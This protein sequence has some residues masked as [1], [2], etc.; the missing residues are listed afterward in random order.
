[1]KSSYKI[2]AILIVILFSLVSCNNRNTFIDKDVVEGNTHEETEEVFFNDIYKNKDVSVLSMK[3]IIIK[4]EIY[5][6]LFR[7]FNITYDE[8][9]EVYENIFLAN[10]NLDHRVMVG[11]SNNYPETF[12]SS[13]FEKLKAYN[14]V[15]LS[16]DEMD[17]LIVETGYD[18]ESEKKFVEDYGEEGFTV[19]ISDSI[20]GYA[21]ESYIFVL[22]SVMQKP[23][24]NLAEYASYSL[25]KYTFKE[26]DGIH[27]LNSKLYK[28]GFTAHSKNVFDET[29]KNPE[30]EKIIDDFN[31]RNNLEDVNFD[32]KFDLKIA[33]EN[34]LD[35]ETE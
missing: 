1:M 29:V 8:L 7:T 5:E 13:D 21:N 23:D 9:R 18:L 16:I 34:L 12:T 4:I 17:K 35:D 27:K 2:T 10:Q 15:A 24:S 14:F 32:Y 6:Y 22:S 19:S 31:S 33:V 25:T 20:K 30:L 3:E 28:D 11:Y 26:I